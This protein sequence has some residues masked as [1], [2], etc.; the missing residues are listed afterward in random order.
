MIHEL[1]AYRLVSGAAAADLV[2][3]FHRD[4]KSDY[5]AALRSAGIPMLAAWSAIRPAGDPAEVVWLRAFESESH[6]KESCDRLYGSPLWRDRLQKEA[7]GLV[8]EVKTLDLTPLEAA[9]LTEGPRDRGF[10]E[11]R[12][13]RLAPNALPRML[14]FFE[15]VRRLVP[16]YGVKVLAWWAAEED[17]MERF[18]WLR[19]FESADAKAR[20]MKELYESD[21]WLSKFKPRALGVI[22]ERILTDLEPLPA[23]SLGG[24]D[25]L[26]F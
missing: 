24:H 25:R 17:G 13:Y 9:A 10:H 6:K 19:E 1:R 3:F 5:H 20:V 8:E 18:L 2:R 4:G 12:H 23:A 22:E 14:A 15:D 7:E 16:K 11:L 26:P 21:L